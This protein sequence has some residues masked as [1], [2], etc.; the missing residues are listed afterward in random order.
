[1]RA[2]LEEHLLLNLERN[3][4][5]VNPG[6]L[7]PIW[8]ADCGLRAEGSTITT[9][10]FSAVPRE[11]NQEQRGLSGQPLPNDKDLKTELRGVVGRMLWKEV[12]GSYI[13][14]DTWWWD[15]PD[16]VEECIKSGTHWEYSL[17]EA[18]KLT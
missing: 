16:C 12:W 6:K 2:W 1:M 13:E 17:I 14:V 15:E 10:K 18:V 9:A 7:F 5:C 8:L 11:L 3:F 4:R